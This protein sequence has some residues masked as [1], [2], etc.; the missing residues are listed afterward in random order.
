MKLVNIENVYGDTLNIVS[1]EGL[2]RM[3]RKDV[4]RQLAD[5]G[6]DLVEINNNQSPVYKIMDYNKFLY[7]KNKKTKQKSDISK[8]KEIKI[9]LN[10]QRHDMDIKINNIRKHLS[11]KNKV[12]IIIQMRGREVLS[13][14]RA[15]KLLR[16]TLPEITNGEASQIK[17]EGK[18]VFVI[19]NPK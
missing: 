17:L 19:V 8:T 6:L 18:L 1:D 15:F 12:K 13:P 7:Q 9:G 14:E 5:G 10:I 4:S 3:S 2:V 11:K 16:E